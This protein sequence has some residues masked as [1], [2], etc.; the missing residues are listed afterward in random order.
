MKFLQA[1]I[2][3]YSDRQKVNQATCFKFVEML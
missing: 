3:F 2:K 1:F